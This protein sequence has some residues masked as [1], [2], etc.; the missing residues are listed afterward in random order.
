M[1]ASKRESYKGT[2]EE[3]K[4]AT[5]DCA[6]SMAPVQRRPTAACSWVLTL[7]CFIPSQ[8]WHQFISHTSYN[9]AGTSNCLHEPSLRPSS[10]PAHGVVLSRAQ[11]L[12]LSLLQSQ[13]HLL[14]TESTFIHTHI[15][16]QRSCPSSRHTQWP[17]PRNPPTWAMAHPCTAVLAPTIINTFSIEPLL[18]ASWDASPRSHPTTSKHTSH[19]CPVALEARPR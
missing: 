16:S 11:V 10:A 7:A 13:T 1:K 17:A 3:E 9:V 6:V 2:H 18:P 8:N 12:A 19:L 5:R 14:T 15:R 4:L